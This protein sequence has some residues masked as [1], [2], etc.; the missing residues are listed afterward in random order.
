[1]LLITALVLYRCQM[2]M[3][4]TDWLMR[5]AWMPICKYLSLWSVGRWQP[6]FRNCIMVLFYSVLFM[7]RLGSQLIFTVSVCQW[8]F[9]L[10]NLCYIFENL[11]LVHFYFASN[12]TW[13]QS[14]SD[15]KLSHCVPSCQERVS[16]WIIFRDCFE[17]S[18]NQV[19]CLSSQHFSQHCS[20]VKNAVVTHVA[21]DMVSA[22]YNRAM[23][24][25]GNWITCPKTALVL[26]SEHHWLT[27]AY[28]L[29]TIQLT[30]S[31][32]ILKY[33]INNK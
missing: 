33:H 10:V 19:F 28:F 25:Q 11:I 13:L 22:C 30:P 4:W 6:S 32:C 27:F 24:S 7:S 14:V 9:S 26:I 8:F 3:R 18:I 15:S 2:S 20:V 16:S 21:D 17:E 31:T 12:C 5:F 1:M 23:S 29:L